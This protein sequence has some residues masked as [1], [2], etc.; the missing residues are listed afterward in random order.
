MLKTVAHLYR[1]L[2][3]SSTKATG[4]ADF[5]DQLSQTD[6]DRLVQRI[7]DDITDRNPAE[8]GTYDGVS[9]EHLRRLCQS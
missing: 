6:W 2:H 7:P 9:V 5:V 8:F 1:N 3:P 4:F